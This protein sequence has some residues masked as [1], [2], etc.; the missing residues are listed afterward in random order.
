MSF[1]TFFKLHKPLIFLAP[2]AMS[3][4]TKRTI[5]IDFVGAELRLEVRDP[6]TE[7]ELRQLGATFETSQL[8]SPSFGP[9]VFET[10]QLWVP[11]LWPPKFR[12]LAA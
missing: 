4:A 2:Q 10:S 3:P 9:H 11:R 8:G 5:L 7:W 1:D 6:H 12:N